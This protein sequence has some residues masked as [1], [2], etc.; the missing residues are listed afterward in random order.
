[1]VKK[2][3]VF[4]GVVQDHIH[5]GKLNFFDVWQMGEVIFWCF[6]NG[7]SGYNTKIYTFEC[8]AR[9]AAGTASDI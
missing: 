9:P 6:E 5:W 4:I 3:V 8:G 2:W 7:G 1:M